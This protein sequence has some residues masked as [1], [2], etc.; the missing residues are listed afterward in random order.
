MVQR[1]INLSLWLDEMQFLFFFLDSIT[2]SLSLC[3][4]QKRSAADISFMVVFSEEENSA[5]SKIFSKLPCSS[6]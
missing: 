1:K 3:I 4:C 2:Q 6:S 5:A